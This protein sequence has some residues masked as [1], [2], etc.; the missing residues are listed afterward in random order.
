MKTKHLT[1]SYFGFHI[2]DKK[3]TI[4]D[5]FQT[6]LDHILTIKT[7]ESTVRNN[8][9]VLLKILH[10]KK[11]AI[12]KINSDPD[13]DDSLKEHNGIEHRYFSFPDPYTGYHHAFG[14]KSISIE[15]KKDI[16]FVHLNKQYQSMLVDAYEFFE[17]FIESIYGCAGYIDNNFWI[18]EDFGNITINE[19]KSKDLEWFIAQASKKKNA[20]KSILSRFRFL[21]K[22]INSIENN[23]KL[24]L[25]F[26]FN[27]TMIEFF[28]HIIVHNNGVIKNKDEFIYNIIKKSET[29]SRDKEL[30][31]E[32][33]NSFIGQYNGKD[34]LL[35]IDRNIS[36]PYPV[37]MY[38][39][40]IGSLIDTL[41]QYA[42]II[43]N[44]LSQY[45]Y[46]ENI[47]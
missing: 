14:H 26:K 34:I 37:N 8:T 42:F 16:H 1:Y 17:D 40:I 25:K 18:A 23:N 22:N 20:P 13:I 45:L 38:I 33:V 46:N 32:H 4:N 44:E 12:D 41:A 47:E 30:A 28:R 2:M 21:L 3:K 27:I 29:S 6:F 19:L 31:K 24:N 43:T 7:Y 35:L 11:I 39:N 5:V 9:E 36:Q 10:D 15:E